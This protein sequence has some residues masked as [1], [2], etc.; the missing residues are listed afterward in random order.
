MIKRVHHLGIAVKNLDETIKIYSKM[1]GKGPDSKMEIATAKM[2][3]A[4]FRVGE[5]TLEF[6]GAGPGS[7]MEEFVKTRGEGIQHIAFEVD[8]IKSELKRLSK[9]G[10]KIV[11][12][13]PRPGPEGDIAFVGPEGAHG[14]YIE[15]MQF[16]K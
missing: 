13:E 8:D 10:V 11:D 15:L 3:V 9:L 14:V 5:V 6:L 1:L 4:N 12:K 7:P 2:G 16:N